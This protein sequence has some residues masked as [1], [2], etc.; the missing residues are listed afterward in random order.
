MDLPAWWIPAREGAPGPAVVLIRSSW[1]PN[2]HATV[3]G[4]ARPVLRADYLM[5]GVAVPTGHHRVL[6]TYDDP[7]VG[8]GLLASGFVLLVLLGGAAARRRKWDRPAPSA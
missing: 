3:D 6:L 5:Q 4:H 1:D 2:W 7:W 8:R